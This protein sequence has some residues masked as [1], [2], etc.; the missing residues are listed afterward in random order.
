MFSLGKFAATEE[1]VLFAILPVSLHVY[2]SAT[3]DTRSQLSFVWRTVDSHSLFS[4][5]YLYRGSICV[6][7]VQYVYTGVGVHACFW[8]SS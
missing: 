6:L 4:T 1:G 7:Y 5:Y 2:L 8:D 3:C